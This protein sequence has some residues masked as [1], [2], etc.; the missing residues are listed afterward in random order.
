[1]PVNTKMPGVVRLPCACAN[2][3]RAA[4][5]VTQFYDAA[6]GPSGLPVTQFTLLQALRLAPGI[7]Q[8]QLAELLGIDSSTLTRTLVPLR[9]K[10]WLRSAAGGDRREVRLSVTAAGNRE[11]ARALPYWESAQKGLRKALGKGN[12]E[13]LME[14]TVRAAGVGFGETTAYDRLPHKS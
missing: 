9:R 10:G 8:K 4:R 3:R 11:Y 5:V 12:W 13:Q 7:S 14:A 2:L 6:L 1:M